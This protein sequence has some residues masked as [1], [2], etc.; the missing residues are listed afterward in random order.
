LL[1][2][3]DAEE[4]VVVGDL[5]GHVANFQAVYK[6]ADLAKNPRRHLVLQE[7]VHGKFRYPLG[8]DKSHQLL[9]LFS[10]LK[11]QFASRVHLLMGNHEMAQWM[12]RPIM[13]A[14]ENLN[15]LFIA[16]L[17]EA[18]GE[19][20]SSIYGAYRRLFAVLPLAIR[21]ENRIFISHSLPKEK[22]LASFSLSTLEQAEH[23]PDD[24]APKGKLYSL[25]W[26][27]DCSAN[28]AAEFLNKV[29]CDWLVT[30]H[31]QCDH[32]FA[33]PNEQQI[34]LDS[35]GEPAAY[36]LFRTDRPLTRNEFYASV[37]LI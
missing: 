25:V 18:Y 29:G 36:A 13:K 10:A 3:R 14:E 16:G 2:L 4:V 9:D 30:G 1:N 28:N 21:T 35:C 31:I 26:G 19:H 7:V 23:A 24:F 37:Y 17:Q 6:F 22:F 27:R 20:A 12:D 5:H 8:G 15:S 33:T 11:I 34:I 32:G